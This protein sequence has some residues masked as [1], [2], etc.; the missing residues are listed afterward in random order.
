MFPITAT[1]FGMNRLLEQ[2]YNNVLGSAPGNM[3][4]IGV[5]AAA[6]ATS[7]F[8]GCPAEYVMIQQQRHNRALGAEMRHTIGTHG[9]LGVYRGIVSV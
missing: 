3:G 7:A 1:Q 4:K 2:T 8:L 9:L 6:G 5:A